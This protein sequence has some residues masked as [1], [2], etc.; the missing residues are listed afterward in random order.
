MKLISTY[1]FIAA[2]AFSA[3]PALAK[4]YD[5]SVRDKG[6][7]NWISER[8]IIKH[9]EKTGD[10]TVIDGLINHYFGKPIA[11]KVNTQND[12]R[13]TFGWTLEGGKSTLPGQTNIR[14]VYRATVFPNTGVTVSGKPV[15]Y[16]NTFRGKG[17]CKITK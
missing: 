17:S 14:V 8:I 5:C 6:N 4:T 9:D 12:K 11:G 2:L 1:G 10:V 13:I 15:G 3:A 7:L 16:G